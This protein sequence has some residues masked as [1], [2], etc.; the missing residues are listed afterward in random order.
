MVDIY[1]GR[2]EGTADERWPSMMLTTADIVD[3]LN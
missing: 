1:S 2:S 3:T